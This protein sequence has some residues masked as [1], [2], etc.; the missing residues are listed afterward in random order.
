MATW[1]RYGASP[2]RVDRSR[3]EAI[4]RLGDIVG[5]GATDRHLIHQRCA[6]VP[7]T[8]AGS[9]RHGPCVMPARLRQRAELRWQGDQLSA[10]Q[11]TRLAR[12]PPQSRRG[13]I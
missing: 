12:L 10:E 1:R 3:A 2:P 13:E 6:L 9:Q 8:T 5:L 4:W 11:L 7:A